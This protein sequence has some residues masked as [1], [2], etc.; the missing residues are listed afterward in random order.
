MNLCPCGA[1]GDPAAECSC[2]PQR[3]AAYREK[4]SRALLDRFDLV[5]GVP[6]ARSREVAGPD[7]EPSAE[8]ARRVAG[9][10]VRLGEE[11]PVVGEDASCLLR[12]AVDQLGLSARGY[13]RAARVA[14]TIAALAGGGRVQ[15]DHVAE[16]LSYRA[17]RGL[18]LAA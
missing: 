13:A 1:R 3:L 2:P 7:G 9:A 6:R 5:V 10:A 11:P 18:S 14:T 4:L 17:P 15:P 16:A 8:V 12:R